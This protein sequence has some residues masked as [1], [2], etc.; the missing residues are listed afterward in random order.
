MLDVSPNQ[1]PELRPAYPIRTERLLLRP[2]TVGDVDALLAYRSRPDVC[3]YVPFDP[4][5]RQLI[6]E[7]LAGHWATVALTDEGQGLTLGIELA[8]TGELVGDVVLFWHSREHRGGEIGYV[9]NPDVA[10]HGYATEAAHALLRL[11]FDELGLHRIVARIDERNDASVKVARRLGMRQEARLVQNEL[12]KGEW[13]TEL[14][15]AMLAEEWPAHR[16]RFA[17]GRQHRDTDDSIIEAP[18]VP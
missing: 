9:L 3:R 15:F 17:D 4:M 1:Q 11:G 7:R 2:L 14:D 8:R 16:D 12:F 13:S 10:G 5:D 6:S 18:A